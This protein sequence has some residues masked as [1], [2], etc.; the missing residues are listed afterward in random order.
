MPRPSTA[1]PLQGEKPVLA[2]LSHILVHDGHKVLRSG[3]NG[4]RQTQ[5]ALVGDLLSS[6]L[7]WV[8]LGGH[9]AGCGIGIL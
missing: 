5:R 8:H 7:V 2:D 9:G 3:G 4:T 1:R 6:S